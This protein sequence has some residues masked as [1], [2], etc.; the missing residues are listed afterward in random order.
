MNDKTDVR[1][2][3]RELLAVEFDRVG[4]VDTA[5]ATR[6]YLPGRIDDEFALRAIEAALSA[7]G[8]RKCCEQAGT[9]ACKCNTFKAPQPVAGDAVRELP[10]GDGFW[11]PACEA[12]YERAKLTDA[13]AAERLRPAFR[14]MIEA[15]L[16]SQPVAIDRPKRDES[17]LRAEANRRGWYTREGTSVPTVDGDWL[18]P[19]DVTISSHDLLALINS[20]A[21]GASLRV[22]D[23]F[24]LVPKVPTE[25]MVEAAMQR[26]DDQP[27]NSWGNIV[28]A[29]H[30]EIYKAMLA[31]AP[32]VDDA[33]VERYKAAHVAE[34]NRF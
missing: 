12:A 1:Q 9:Y 7:T 33:M 5:R 3:A 32:V 18:H 26:E 34:F 10:G 24:V 8:G 6:A 21:I 14:S 17:W 2:R 13:K 15:A 27:L 31:A 19:F 20:V 11:V 30:E 25:A 16:R 22:P 23:G 29:P 28:H 4:H